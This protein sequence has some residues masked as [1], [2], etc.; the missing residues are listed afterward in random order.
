MDGIV[1]RLI[2]IG[3]LYP[4][5]VKC[6]LLAGLFLLEF[7]KGLCGTGVTPFEMRALSTIGASRTG[8]IVE[9]PFYVG[10]HAYAQAV[11]RL[12]SR[13]SFGSFSGFA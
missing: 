5:F 7:I 1:L 4:R 6:V 2:V 13:R 11:V 8:F 9:S 12:L 3:L 10:D